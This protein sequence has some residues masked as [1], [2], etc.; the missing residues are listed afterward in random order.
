MYKQKAL[1]QFTTYLDW[2]HE[3]T[4]AHTQNDRTKWSLLRPISDLSASCGLQVE[5]TRAPARG[6]PN[7]DTGEPRSAF[8]APL[9]ACP[10]SQSLSSVSLRGT[11]RTL[12]APVVDGV[13]KL[14]ITGRR[15]KKT[16][17]MM[18]KTGPRP[19]PR[20]T[21]TDRLTD[22]QTHSCE[23]PLPLYILPGALAQASFVL[24]RGLLRR[25]SFSCGA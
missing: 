18:T 8:R 6:E 25:G 9:G 21:S 12:A 1:T 11:A 7:P 4:H 24:R 15:R 22:R 13:S 3:H 16:L 2:R 23:D 10:G 19:P 14:L 20:P 17:T 5:S